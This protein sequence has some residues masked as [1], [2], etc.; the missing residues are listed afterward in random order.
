MTVRS[1]PLPVATTPLVSARARDPLSLFGLLIVTVTLIVTRPQPLSPDV[2]LSLAGAGLLLC[3]ALF[4]PA[5]P[6]YLA[7]QLALVPL[8][9][10]GLSP[11]FGLAQLA[12]ACLLVEPAR[13][14]G[15]W[16]LTA[17][18]IIIGA[19]TGAILLA[20]SSRG[21]ATLGAVLCLGVG[22][23]VYLTHRLTLVRLDL[24]ARPPADTETTT[25]DHDDTTP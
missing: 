23:G 19:G 16:R 22:V 10:G 8:F 4:V 6:A 18:T 5:V 12:L 1:S 14:H 11:A 25:A 17:V 15:R 21:V 2:S 20:G 9:T 24:V 3:V 7:G 13:A